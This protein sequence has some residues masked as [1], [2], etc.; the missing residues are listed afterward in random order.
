[1]YN[2]F[3]IKTILCNSKVI[4]PANRRFCFG[5]FILINLFLVQ[6][7]H[8]EDLSKMV[9]K[10]GLPDVPGVMFLK[11]DGSPGGFPAEILEYAA[12]DEGIQLEWVFAPWPVLFEKLKKGEIDVLPGVT[13]NSD[14]RSYLDF[15]DNSL[16]VTW[17]ELYISGRSRFQSIMD[18][19][20]KRIGLVDNDFNSEGF[21]KYISG[22]NISYLPVYFSSHKEAVEALNRGEIFAV[23]GPMSKIMAKTGMNLKNSGLFFNPSDSSIAFPKGLHAELRRAI[24]RRIGILKNTPDSAFVRLF[25]YYGLSDL[26]RENDYIPEWLIYAF[27]FT[28]AFGFVAALFVVALRHKVGKKNLEIIISEGKLN[29]AAEL[30]RLGYWEMDHRTGKTT[31]SSHLRQILETDDSARKENEILEFI[32]PDDREAVLSA[33][34]ASLVPGSRYLIQHRIVTGKGNIRWLDEIGYTEFSASGTPIYTFGVSIDVTEK[35]QRKEEIRRYEQKFSNIFNAID[36]SVLIHDPETLEIIYANLAAFKMFGY[37]PEKLAGLTM[38]DLS[39][40]GCSDSLLR[41]IVKKVGAADGVLFEWT[42]KNSSGTEFPVEI[43]LRM[44][45][46]GLDKNYISVIRNIAQRKKAEE[47]LRNKEE[48][49]H[50]SQKMESLGQ[51]AGGIAH[52]FNNMLFG[53]M[54]Y[55]E[56][57][58]KKVE[59]GKLDEYCRQIVTTSQR[60]A[61]LTKQLLSFARKGKEYSMPVDVHGCIESAISI[62]T[63]TVD[64]SVVL[65]KIL[66]A[67]HSYVVGDPA[68][69]Q[70]AFLNLGLN[71][72]DAMPDGGIFIITTGE[73]DLSAGFCES[74]SSFDIRPGKYIY[75]KASDSGKGIP[76]EFLPRIFEPFFTTKKL[77]QGTG[78]GL[79]AVYGTVAGH[80]GLITVSSSAD[81]G[82]V[83]EIYLPL[84]G[85]HSLPEETEHPVEVLPTGLGTVLVVDDEKVVREMVSTILGDLGY[86]T[87]QAENGLEAVEKF[88]INKD[89]IGLVILDIIM[90]EMGGVEAYERIMAIDPEA[91]VVISSGYASGER[92]RFFM[93]KDISAFLNKPFTYSVL[94]ETVSKAIRKNVS[95]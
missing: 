50:H 21:R 57:I 80:G 63:R 61:D 53:I 11:Q 87:I 41:E 24:D 60:A 76:Q 94:A 7:S 42:V 16:Y 2:A 71:A 28:T 59:D 56:I 66:L 13:V 83:F 93:D 32:H 51:L 52:D 37:A 12:K 1:M 47:E 30:A 25:T 69:L 62:L 33:F 84:A 78:L 85:G 19:K 22:F 29:S 74:F 68:Q 8:A 43:A 35:L 91:R 64:K 72:R 20:D 26:K 6:V 34:R 95:A 40:V 45:E 70:S 49:L 9:Y 14:R 89:I 18:I 5:F 23:A 46:T 79:A 81:T 48:L 77:G 36:E 39:G 86:E 38:T 15:I 54:G 31:W 65:K 88:G 73:L 90:P 67:R 58:R 55:A 3:K 4:M 75:I 82:T 27:V 17:S 92:I 10:A 44:A